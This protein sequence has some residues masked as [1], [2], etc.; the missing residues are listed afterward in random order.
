MRGFARNAPGL[1]IARM[2]HPTVPSA[3]PSTR[4]PAAPAEVL[5]PSGSPRFGAY[6]GTLP[7]VDLTR[8]MGL[9]GLTGRLR[10]LATR[11][12]WTYGCVAT[13]EV[14]AGFAV[15]DLGYAS[16]AFVFVADLAGGHLVSDESFLGLP[17]VSAHVAPRPGEGALARFRGGGGSFTWERPPGQSAYHVSI[18]TPRVRLEATLETT[19]APPMLAALL[20]LVTGDVDCTQKGNLLPLAGTLEADGR[21]FALDGGHGGFDYT[22]G[23]FGRHTAWRWAFALGRAQDGTPVGLNVTS[24]LSDAAKNENVLW[25]P[26]RLAPLPPPRFAFDPARPMEPWRIDTA[27][28]ALQLRFTPAGRHLEERSLGLVSSRFLQ[29]AGTFAGTMRTPDGRTLEVEGLPGVT[30]DQR[31]KW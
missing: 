5:D 2:T 27:D 12:H 3:A 29:V 15:V 13:R 11:K 6:E 30:E 9:S 20:P 18:V 19:G 16:N 24:G 17:G 21:R 8:R 14:F 4:L 25:T 22:Q 26:D 7:E 23:L 28:G 1:I 10:R 31:V